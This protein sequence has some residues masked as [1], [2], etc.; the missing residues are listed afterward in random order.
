[1]MKMKKIFML[2]LVAVMG[3]ALAS[4]NPAVAINAANAGTNWK[5]GFDGV[6]PPTPSYVRAVLAF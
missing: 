5:T 3:V 4:S 6:N 2:A 1:M